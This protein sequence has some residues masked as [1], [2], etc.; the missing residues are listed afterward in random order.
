[1]DYYHITSVI[2]DSDASDNEKEDPKNF[3]EIKDQ[4]SFENSHQVLKT[5]LS[6]NTVEDIMKE[7]NKNTVPQNNNNVS[8]KSNTKS[9]TPRSDEV[10]LRRKPSRSSS[11]SHRASQR[12]SRLLEGVTSITSLVSLPGYTKEDNPGAQTLASAPGTPGQDLEEEAGP[13]SLPYWVEASQNI[14]KVRIK[15]FDMKVHF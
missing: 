9:P 4:Q 7:Y 2:E 8:D 5:C 15:L 10:V 14:Y 11:Y 1:M 6:N 13:T 12:F 3:R